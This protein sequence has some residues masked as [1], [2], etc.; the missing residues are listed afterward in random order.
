MADLTLRG[1]SRGVRVEAGSLL[2]ENVELRQTG[3]AAL[4]EGGFLH[5]RRALLTT[6]GRAARLTAGS[7]RME[8]CTMVDQEEG[9]LVESGAA[10][11]DVERSL[12]ARCTG[13]LV[14]VEAGG[15][16]PAVG[17]SDFWGLYGNP[18]P[19][20]GMPDP[21][22]G[23]GNLEVDPLFCDAPGG[24]WSLSSLSPLLD[25]GACG[26]VGARGEGC[27]EPAVDAPAARPAVSGLQS[28]QPN[29]FNPRA[30]ILFTTARRGPVRLEV[31]DARGRR[32]RGLVHAVLEAG[33]HRSSWDGRDGSCLLYTSPSPRD[34]TRSRMPSSA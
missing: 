23:S 5:L 14:E 27:L 11:L 21:R 32:V 16:L 2:L 7:M 10:G 12:F 18:Q 25:A 31:Y 4:V 3:T 26:E 15:P 29:P 30:T 17:C 1:G 13:T 19:F 9:L 8:A 34:R 22:G 33:E 6:S 20:V 28:V 24:E